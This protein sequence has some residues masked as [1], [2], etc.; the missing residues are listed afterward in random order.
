[1]N[2]C[3][4]KGSGS[5]SSTV[6]ISASIKDQSMDIGSLRSTPTIQTSAAPPARRHVASVAS[7]TSPAHRFAGG[8]VSTKEA[9]LESAE[10]F[11]EMP[12]PRPT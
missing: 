6:G 11:A 7:N 8:A 5:S 2:A 3:A 10:A 1:M 9:L 4:M 12:S